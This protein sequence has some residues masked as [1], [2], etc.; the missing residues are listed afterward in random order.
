MAKLT[1]K[2]YKRKKIAF[3]AVIL[4]GVALVSSGF[5][6]W[7][8]SSNAE[9]KVQGSVTVGTIEKGSLKM[10]I[11][12]E[13]AAAGEAGLNSG[14]FNF[15]TKADDNT[16]RVR[17]KEGQTSED[18]ENLSLSYV[19]TVKSPID[20]FKDLKYRMSATK[21]AVDYPMQDVS[22]GD[23]TQYIV[24]PEC[25]GKDVSIVSTDTSV[26]T[27]TPITENVEENGKTIV[28]KNKWTATITIAF[29]WGATFGGYNPGLYYDGQITG[30][31]KPS[32]DI[33]ALNTAGLAVKDEV[34]ET[35]LNDLKTKLDGATYNID[36]VASVN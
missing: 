11:S 16:G 3:A 22:E 34:V 10:E 6:A 17:A 23:G 35:K 7:V 1:R 21:S 2:S 28:Y 25:F 19:V 32:E 30:S 29:Q 13:G 12:L 33:N 20:N 5:A 18:S 4:G 26:F 24:L 15:N 9:K 8:L 36:F 14:K 31:G 27:R